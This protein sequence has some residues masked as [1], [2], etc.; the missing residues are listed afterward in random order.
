[1]MPVALSDTIAVGEVPSKEQIAILASAGFRSLLSTQP[2]G[3]VQRLLSSAECFSASE[4]HG[5]VYRH[6]AIES[7][8]PSDDDIT[9]FALALAEMPKPIYACCYSG[10]RTAAVWALAAAA[11]QE[12]DKIIGAAAAVGYDLQFMRDAL[13]ARHAA[14]KPTPQPVNNGVAPDV[15]TDVAAASSDPAPLPRPAA[16]PQLI[17]SSVVPRAASAGGFAVAG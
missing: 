4:H 9:A 14:H 17:P 5:L 3:E 16:V 7:R 6:V 12:A 1:M 2:D 8:R 15:T 13:L 10:A 11:T